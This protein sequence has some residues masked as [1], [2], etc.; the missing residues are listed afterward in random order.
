MKQQNEIIQYLLNTKNPYQ[1]KIGEI[2]VEME[3]SNNDK[4]FNQCMINILKGKIGK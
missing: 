1:I 3:Y 4:T 2:A